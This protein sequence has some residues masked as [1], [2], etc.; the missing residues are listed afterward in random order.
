MKVYDKREN[1]TDKE[2]IPGQMGITIQESIL[3]N[4]TAKAHTNI[5]YIIT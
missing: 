3:V 1:P 2:H 4:P 5:I